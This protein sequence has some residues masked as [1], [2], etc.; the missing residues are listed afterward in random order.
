M[1]YDSHFEQAVRGVWSWLQG[2]TSGEVILI[3]L[4]FRSF[5]QG[6]KGTAWYTTFNLFSSI[7]SQ[8]NRGEEEHTAMCIL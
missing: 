2:M 5:S 6:L 7:A 4:C 8:N 3:E 1:G